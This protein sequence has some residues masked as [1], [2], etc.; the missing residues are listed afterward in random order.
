MRNVTVAIEP[1]KLEINIIILKF[2]L[3]LGNLLV[4][5]FF[6]ILFGRKAR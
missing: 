5:F 6:F 4:Y 3:F 2:N 1:K